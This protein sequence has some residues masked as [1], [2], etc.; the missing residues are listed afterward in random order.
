MLQAFDS[1]R[2]LGK[3]EKWVMSM[4]ISHVYY[5]FGLIR[6]GRFDLADCSINGYTFFQILF[7]IPQRFSHQQD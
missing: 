7:Y 1:V 5:H 4:F 3:L 2:F 6:A